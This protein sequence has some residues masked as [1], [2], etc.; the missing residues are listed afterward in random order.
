MDL[1]I[2]ICIAWYCKIAYFK[3][4]QEVYVIF[5]DTPSKF[6][7]EILFHLSTIM[8]APIAMTIRWV[9]KQWRWDT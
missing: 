4:I 1:F 8:I 2:I 5:R 6:H 3:A 7:D 9:R